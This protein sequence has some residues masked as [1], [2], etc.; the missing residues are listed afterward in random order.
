MRQ[1]RRNSFSGIS[2]DHQ[3]THKNLVQKKK[4]LIETFTVSHPLFDKLIETKLNKCL[5]HGHLRNY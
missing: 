4:N 1:F 3:C 5:Q 2:S